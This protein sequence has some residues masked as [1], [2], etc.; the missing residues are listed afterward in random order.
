MYCVKPSSKGGTRGQAFDV[1]AP[2]ISPWAKSHATIEP[3]RRWAKPW[4]R[5][6]AG[7]DVP[8]I[9]ARMHRP[10]VGTPPDAVASGRLTHPADGAGSVGWAKALLRRAHHPVRAGH[11][12]TARR[13]RLCPP[14]EFCACR[15]PRHHT[16]NAITTAPARPNQVM[17]YCK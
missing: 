5:G 12:G 13:A 9:A 7:G 14:Y 4:P 8:T 17:A 6:C 15:C 2:S 10:M 3:F 11:G 16:P 1:T